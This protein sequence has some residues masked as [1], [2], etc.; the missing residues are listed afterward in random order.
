MKKSKLLSVLTAGA[1]IATTAGTYAVWDKLNAETTAQAVEFRNPVTV[2]IDTD[3]SVKKDN[4]GL[5][6]TPTATGTASFT[7][8]NE[9]GLA[10]K[11]VLKPVIE[12]EHGITT[13]DFDFSVFD[14]DSSSG[15]PIIGDAVGGFA[16]NSLESLNYTI[17]ITP[18][19]ADN[20][21]GKNVKLK[22]T[23]ELTE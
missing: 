6:Q 12:S 11:L 2:A 23:A 22:L 15:T 8:D 7:V 4:T 14:G 9:D 5:G 21:K 17:Q 1:V 3:L 18:K 19:N 20:I 16:D 10:K 13:N